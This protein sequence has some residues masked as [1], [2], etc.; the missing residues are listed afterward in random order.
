MEETQSNLEASMK[1]LSVVVSLL[2]LGL[3]VFGLSDLIIH[4]GS[5]SVPGVVALSPSLTKPGTSIS[6]AL[7]TMSA[8]IV[9]LALLPV[10]RVLLA[11][12]LYIR[13]RQ[14]LNV[15]VALLV[16]IELLASLRTGA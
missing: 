14:V 4:G 11:L 6:P 8:G 1:K 16:F 3:M 2:G 9:I 10:V 7:L 15:V 12:L 13:N 5:L